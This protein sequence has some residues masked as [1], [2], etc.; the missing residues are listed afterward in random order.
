MH[1]ECLTRVVS[2]QVRGSSPAATWLSDSRPSNAEWLGNPYARVMRLARHGAGGQFR[3]ATGIGLQPNRYFSRR[4]RPPYSEARRAN[5]AEGKC[6][7]GKLESCWSELMRAAIRGDAAAYRQLLE[8]LAPVLRRLVNRELHRC[9]SG[10]AEDV[11]QEALLA[12]HLKRHTWDPSRPFL[13][14]VWAIARNKLT[15]A[16]RRRPR[17]VHLPIDDMAEV[18]ASDAVVDTDRVDAARLLAGL[19]GRRREIVYSIF[20]EGASSREVAERLG[21][22]EGTVRVALHRGVQAMARAFRG[23]MEVPTR[24]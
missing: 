11:V 1:G 20:V 21:M 9:D 2:G 7:V 6:M 12:L 10:E 15:D 8:E 19:K 5:L 16:L 4:P 17:Q 22:N 3:Y 23:G 13:P 14:W 18:L 24:S